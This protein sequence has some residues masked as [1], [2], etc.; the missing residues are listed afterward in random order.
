VEDETYLRDESLLL[1]L[2]LDDLV[3]DGILSDHLEDTDTA[4]EAT[5]ADT[6]GSGTGVTYG[7]VCPIR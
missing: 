5:S 6:I 2:D 4:D 3:L 1:G 7:L